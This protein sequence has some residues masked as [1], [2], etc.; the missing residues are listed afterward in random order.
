M[1]ALLTKV[2]IVK[3]MV[4]P[5]VMYGCESWTKK[6]AEH[7]RADASEL[8]CWRRLWRVPWTARRS[9]Q[10]ILKEINPEYSLEGLIL[11]LKL[12]YLAIGCKEL[13][14]WKRPWYWERLKAGGEGDDRGWAG[15]MASLT[16]WTWVW[17]NSGSWW[18]TGKPGV[19]QSMGSQ[20]V[21]HDLVTN[22]QCTE[23]YICF[24]S[25]IIMLWPFSYVTTYF[26]FLPR[27]SILFMDVKKII[28]ILK[29]TWAYFEVEGK[30]C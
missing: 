22:Q 23:L 2:H 24:F 11:K 9:N 15:G 16:Q 30:M 10:S 29:L 3:T 8:W 18:W 28:F 7:W 14:H 17:A 27:A 21:G 25:L 6:K 4:F 12:Q 5:G 13:T 20:R 1:L 26:F 19:L